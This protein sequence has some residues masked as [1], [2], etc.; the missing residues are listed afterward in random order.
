MDTSPALQAETWHGLVLA[1][2]PATVTVSPF[3]LP[4]VV[5]VTLLELV[6]APVVTPWNPSGRLLA[7]I[8]TPLTP[9]PAMRL[10]VTI[11]GAGA[12]GGDVHTPTGRHVTEMD[13]AAAVREAGTVIVTGDAHRAR[14]VDRA[15][16]F[17]AA[18]GLESPPPVA[19]EHTVAVVSR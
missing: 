4:V 9:E 2:M 1:V 5:M 11:N 19:L 15:G 7:C 6:M 17:H 12:V 10:P 18:T 16:D 8:C 3:V 14:R 13:L